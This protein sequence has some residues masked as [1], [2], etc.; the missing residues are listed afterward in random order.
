LKFIYTRSGTING[1]PISISDTFFN[2]LWY[3]FNNNQLF[4]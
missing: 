1:R 3:L 4:F 2:F